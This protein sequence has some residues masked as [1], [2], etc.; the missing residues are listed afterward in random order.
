MPMTTWR[1]VLGILALLS[2]QLLAADPAGA[3]FTRGLRQPVPFQQVT[4]ED[5]FW[6]PKLQ[7]YRQRTVPHSWQ[8]VRRE[9]EDNEIAAGWRKETRGKDTPWNQANLHKVLET[10]AY[11][12]AQDPD[13]ALAAKVS[14]I[15][16]AIAAAQQPDGY[17][18]ALVTVRNMTP[19]AE[20][21][22]QHDGYVA[23][24]LIEA[25]V[26][27]HLATGQT[28][29][30]AVAQR[31]ARHIHQHF[32]VEKNPG[33]CGHAELELA[34]VRLHRVTGDPLPRELAKEW[35]ERRG[36]PAPHS[37]D[38]ERSYFMDHLPIREV[39]EV[40]GHAV[41]TMFY[42][43]GVAEVAVETGDRG[44]SAAA[45]RLWRDVTERRMYLTGAVGSQEKDEG[46]GR[47][48]ELPNSPGYNESCAACGVVYC[49]QAMFRLDGRAA[50]MEVLERTFYNAVL[51]G[52]SLDGT[53]TYYRN[54][55]TDARRAR[56]NIWVCCPPCLSR[57]LLRLPEYVYAQDAESLYVNLY[58]G[59]TAHAMIGEAKV[60]LRQTGDLLRNGQMRFTVS[61]EN[62]TRFRLLLRRP[63]WSPDVRVLLNSRPVKPA[64]LRS[65]YLALDRLWNPGDTVD[66]NFAMP[67][68]QLVD[69]PRVIPNRGRTAFV[70]GPLVYGAE[71]LDNAGL[72]D[73]IVEAGGKATT[74]WRDDLLGGV[75]VITWKGTGAPLTLVPFFAMANR[76][77]T[78]QRVWLRDGRA[79]HSLTTTSPAH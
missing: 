19:W 1:M 31:L 51:H 53:N 30:L 23:G 79:R 29:F 28:N 37:S 45:R 47:P 59:S 43:T 49:A 40:T 60:T 9:I 21:D 57:T 25:A 44:L 38:T 7:V 72:D 69:D 63:D 77:P 73:P 22:G 32:V 4:I 24:H 61:P 35:I 26:A 14:D 33:V 62:A 64:T 74:V 34:L 42:L 56:N 76:E 11:A 17:C 2:T 6:S 58:V 75:P 8:Y 36:R 27:H 3:E 10:A 67:V 13:P 78:T 66:V 65:G 18:N 16:Q 39:R 15:V 68:R 70:K 46:F 20:L 71:G 54:P 52:I 12:L 50:A 55:L 41:R 48:H 5:S